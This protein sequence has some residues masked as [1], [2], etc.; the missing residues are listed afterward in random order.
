[1]TP[2][3]SHSSRVTEEEDSAMRKTYKLL[4]KNGP[5]KKN[6][7]AVLLHKTGRNIDCVLMKFDS[8]G[9]PLGESDD[10]EISAFCEDES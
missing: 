8:L 7:F 6:I 10:G 3:L 1:M 5:M 9:L 4:Q 2:K